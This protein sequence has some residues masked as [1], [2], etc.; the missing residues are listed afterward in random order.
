[1][2]R[3]RPAEA[4]VIY[5]NEIGSETEKSDTLEINPG[6]IGTGGRADKSLGEDHSGCLRT[7][8]KEKSKTKEFWE[9]ACRYHQKK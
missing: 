3:G 9:T 8:E 1:M 4:R 5:K 7:Y 6:R 2:A